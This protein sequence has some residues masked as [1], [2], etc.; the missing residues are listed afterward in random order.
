MARSAL[1]EPKI[2]TN[3]TQPARR[4]APAVLDTCPSPGQREARA[5]GWRETPASPSATPRGM[6][7]GIRTRLTQ[8]AGRATRTAPTTPRR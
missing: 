2:N 1:A 8:G 5:P 6:E 3:P 4:R 7:C